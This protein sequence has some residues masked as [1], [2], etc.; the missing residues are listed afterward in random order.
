MESESAV[1]LERRKTLLQLECTVEQLQVPKIDLSELN[2]YNIAVHPM[3]FTGNSDSQPSFFARSRSL[4]EPDDELLEREY[5]TFPLENDP[6]VGNYTTY[7]R[8]FQYNETG[9]GVL[10]MTDRSGPDFPHVK[11]I[12]YN[13]VKATDQTILRGELLLILR[14]MF[15]QLRKRRFL[16]H[17]VAPVLLFSIVGPQHARIIEAIFD[18]SNLVLRTTKIFDLCYKNV[19]GLKDFAEYYLGPP[20]GDTVK[21]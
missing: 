14:L 1:R 8:L 6:S 15:T 16:K 4:P 11:A 21:T 20:I 13:N 5:P 3:T 18:G 12:A 2:N 9:F 10:Y 19:Q 7:K 17:M